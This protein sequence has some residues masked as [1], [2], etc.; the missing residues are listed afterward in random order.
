MERSDGRGAADDGEAIWRAVGMGQRQDRPSCRASRRR[1]NVRRLEH[2][3]RDHGL[4]RLAQHRSER[5]DVRRVVRHP[6][7]T[8]PG[9]AVVVVMMLGE[10]SVDQPRRT[11]A[12]LGSV[13]VRRPTE[14]QMCER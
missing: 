10:V 11:M 13:V 3:K 5:H 6:A 7:L 4:A 9:G 1:W 12:S 8:R 14:V 2:D